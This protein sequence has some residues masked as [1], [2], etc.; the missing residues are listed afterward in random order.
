MAARLLPVGGGAAQL[1]CC[2]APAASPAPL[3]A[4]YFKESPEPFYRLAKELFPGQFRPTPAH[5]F[6]RLLHDKGLLLR[7][8]TQV[9]SPASHAV[10]LLP[11]GMATAAAWGSS[12]PPR[13]RMAGAWLHTGNIYGRTRKDSPR[14]RL[15]QG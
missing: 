11:P 14:R 12:S 10:A 15:S 8:Y 2:R 7:C 6:I 5:H 4:Q 1:L 3:R 9:S 13:P